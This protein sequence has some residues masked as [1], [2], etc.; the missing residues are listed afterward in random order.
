MTAADF[1]QVLAAYRSAARGAREM[2]CDALEIHGAH[3]Y[4]LDS[5]LSP[6]DNRRTDEYGG[7][8]KNRMRF[9][10]EVVRTI[11]SVVGPD[12]PIIYR[13]SQWKV[14]DYRELKFRTP[15]DLEVWVTALRK[16]GVDILHVSTRDVADPGFEAEGPRTLAAWTRTLSGLPVIGVGKVS[17][18][19][20]MDQAYGEEKD[21]IRDPAPALDLVER[22][23]IDLLAVGRALI[24]NVEWVR[25]VREGRW[26]DLV[27][28]NKSQLKVL[29]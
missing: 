26:R 2:G 9:P 6:V 5:F 25:L 20:P 21:V 14:N 7:S 11:R 28:F 17:V 16:A 8:M 13:F 27:P 29:H 4:L 10:L 24:P 3:G 19:L 22:G 23:E 1:E 15:A 18:T 12:F